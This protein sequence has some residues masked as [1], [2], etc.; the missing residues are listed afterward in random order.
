MN[1][2]MEEDRICCKAVIDEYILKLEDTD[3]NIFLKNLKRNHEEFSNR[4]IGAIR[5]RLQNIKAVLEKLHI[6]NTLPLSPLSNFSPQTEK[7][8]KEELSKS[9]IVF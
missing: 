1:W 2:A 5:M 9:G 4:E 6:K 7:I 8:L 3:K